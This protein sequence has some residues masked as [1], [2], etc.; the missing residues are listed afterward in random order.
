M[1]FLEILNKKGGKKMN[2]KR[3]SNAIVAVVSVV[4]TIAVVGIGLILLTACGYNIADIA[5]NEHDLSYNQILDLETGRTLTLGDSWAS[6][7]DLIELYSD[8]IIV[9]DEAE[10]YF[11]EV[12]VGYHEGYHFSNNL[13]HFSFDDVSGETLTIRVEYG[14]IVGFNNRFCID[15]DLTKSRFYFPIHPNDILEP[16]T[17]HF[18]STD[19]NSFYG[20]EFNTGLEAVER[21]AADYVLGLTVDY[22]V[23]NIEGTGRITQRNI[24]FSPENVRRRLNE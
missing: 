17:R 9:N 8:Y 24:R 13:Y 23:L 2:E 22:G 7:M 11:D 6:N 12:G 15:C 5:D 21:S 14:I 19:S 18:T 20:L 16:D 1:T 10:L 3:L 4:A